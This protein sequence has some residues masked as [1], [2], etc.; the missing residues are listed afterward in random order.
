MPFDM[1]REVLKRLEDTKGQW[2]K[3]AKG[4]RVSKRTLE[5]IARG[6]IVDP[7]V[8]HIQKLYNYF[9]RQDRRASS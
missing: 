4:S 1:H 8:S 3:V 9:H 2:P 7:G 6:L 5:K